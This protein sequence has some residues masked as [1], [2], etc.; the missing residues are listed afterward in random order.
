M[1]NNK[2]LGPDR[3]LNKVLKIVCPDLAEPLAEAISKYLIVGTLLELYKEL[4]TVVLRKDRKRDYSLLS[5]YRPIALENTLV[6]LIEK[7]IANCIATV[8]EEHALLPW[9]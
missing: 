1:L 5:S 6:K 7:I 9:T 3:I 2:V 4:T 8:A